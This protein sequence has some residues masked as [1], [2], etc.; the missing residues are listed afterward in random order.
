MKNRKGSKKDY[1]GIK[2][3]LV[4]VDRHGVVSRTITG[5]PSRFRSR[6]E[7]KSWVKCLIKVMYG[8][9]KDVFGKILEF[10]NEGEYDNKHDALLAFDAFIE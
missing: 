7:G 3:I 2:V 8:K 5:T 6:I 9:K 4:L 1:S 10:T